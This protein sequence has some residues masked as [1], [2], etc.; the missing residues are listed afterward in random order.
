MTVCSTSAPVTSL[1]GHKAWN[2]SSWLCRVYLPS[3]T[4]PSRPIAKP[5][6][7]SNGL[8]VTWSLTA[9]RGIVAHQM[10]RQAMETSI[11]TQEDRRA[12]FP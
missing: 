12:I 7:I 4:L 2:K 9:Q 10:V 1:D 11:R 3:T 8:C 5:A 6:D